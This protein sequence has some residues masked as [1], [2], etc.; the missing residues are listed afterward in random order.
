MKKALVFFLAF[1]S[2]VCII[3]SIG[4]LY[5]CDVPS[6]NF[7]ATGMIPIGGVFIYHAWLKCKEYLQ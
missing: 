7:F 5:Y 6:S 1:F 3:G 2:V 4:T